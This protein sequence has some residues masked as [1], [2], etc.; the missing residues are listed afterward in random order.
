MSCVIIVWNMDGE[1]NCIWL[2]VAIRVTLLK[3]CTEKKMY[4]TLHRELNL[5]LLLYLFLFGSSEDLFFIQFSSTHSARKEG[6][7]KKNRQIFAGFDFVLYLLFEF[8]HSPFISIRFRFSSW[9]FLFS[10][11]SSPLAFTIFSSESAY[12]WC[13]I[14]CGRWIYR[15]AKKQNLHSQFTLTIRLPHSYLPTQSHIKTRYKRANV[16]IQFNNRVSSKSHPA[17]EKK[18]KETWKKRHTKKGVKI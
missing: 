9:R 8:F 15:S 14:W 3:M 17:R 16:K 11:S 2:L 13:C 4:G 10:R 6:A 12:F 5:L 1:M 18:W 7:K